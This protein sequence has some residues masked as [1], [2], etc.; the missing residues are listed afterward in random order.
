MTQQD[1]SLPTAGD[2]WGGTYIEAKK[3]KELAK[4]HEEKSWWDQWNPE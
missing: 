1:I 2:F 3:V 4:E